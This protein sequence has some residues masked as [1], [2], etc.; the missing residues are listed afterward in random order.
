MYRNNIQQKSM[1]NV[2]QMTKNELDK[3]QYGNHNNNN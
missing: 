1:A 3:Q 2:V